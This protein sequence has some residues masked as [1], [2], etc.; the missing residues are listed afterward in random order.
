MKTHTHSNT[1]PLRSENKLMFRMHVPLRMLGTLAESMFVF[2]VKIVTEHSSI[3]HLFYIQD[4]GR[5]LSLLQ[6]NLL[7]RSETYEQQLVKI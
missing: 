2:F 4:Y 1:S 3:S 7:I 5:E 6:E